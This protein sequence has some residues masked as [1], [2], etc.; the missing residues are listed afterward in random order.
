MVH[1]RVGAVDTL[2]GRRLADPPGLLCTFLVLG[3]CDAEDRSDA[4]F[5]FHDDGSDGAIG[6]AVWLDEHA[7]G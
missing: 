5:R 2:A 7:A 6:E 4:C 3:Y 1:T